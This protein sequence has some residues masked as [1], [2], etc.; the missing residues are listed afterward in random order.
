MNRLRF[1]L[2]P[3]WLSASDVRDILA[4]G[5]LVGGLIFLFVVLA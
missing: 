5:A 1:R 2:F 3:W 4:F